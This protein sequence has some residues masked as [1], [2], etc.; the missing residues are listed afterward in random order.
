[1]GGTNASGCDLCL[2]G[3]WSNTTRAS[4]CHLCA[5][6]RWS[7]SSGASDVS[8]C[9]LCQAGKWSNTM[10]ST[11]CEPCDVGRWTITSGADDASLCKVSSTYVQV[12]FS[13]TAI[14]LTELNQSAQGILKTNVAKTLA[15]EA[16][17]DPKQV[18]ISL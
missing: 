15:T 5:A 1:M 14:S 3:M 8:A 7:T 10:A 12:S 18:R 2:A 13:L 9:Q 6:G 4:S 17:V 11:Q 16:G